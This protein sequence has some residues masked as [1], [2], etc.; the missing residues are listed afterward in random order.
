MSYNVHILYWILYFC[1]Q[2]LLKFYILSFCLLS[3]YMFWLFPIMS[4]SLFCRFD[5]RTFRCFVFRC[6]VWHPLKLGGNNTQMIC[7][8][9]NPSDH[10]SLN[11]ILMERSQWKLSKTV[12]Y[13]KIYFMRGKLLTFGV[14]CRLSP[15]SSIQ[16]STSCINP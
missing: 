7:N 11:I 12:S 10:I 3:Y 14:S 13:L 9:S 16:Q 6:F 15:G 1:Q 5:V 4:H 2:H 8:F